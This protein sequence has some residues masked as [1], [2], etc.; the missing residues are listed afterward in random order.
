MGAP[1]PS[2]LDGPLGSTASQFAAVSGAVGE[3][4]PGGVAKEAK[5][6]AFARLNHFL[7]KTH[8]LSLVTAL[9]EDGFLSPAE[10]VA[11]CHQLESKA[12]LPDF[13]CGS[14]AEFLRG[15]SLD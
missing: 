8:V 10:K 11:A 13:V 1:G 4:P 6:A 2:P 12:V 7:L 14:Y 5:A 9:K 15:Q 3:D